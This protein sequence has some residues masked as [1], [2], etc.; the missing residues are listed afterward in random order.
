MPNFPFQCLSLCEPMSKHVYMFKCSFEWFK[1]CNIQ[2][3]N[4]WLVCDGKVMKSNP[5]LQLVLHD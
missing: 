5:I 2:G 4:A 1:T 3:C